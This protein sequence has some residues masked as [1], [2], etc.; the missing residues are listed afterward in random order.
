M[1]IVNVVK[2][3][4]IESAPFNWGISLFSFGCNLQ[5][6]FCKGYNYEA[7]TDKRNIIGDVLD[8]LEK[9]V[10]PAHDCVIF[11]GG[12]PTIWK[13][14]LIKALFW[15]KKHN[16]KTKIFSNGFD[17]E[18]IRIINDLKLCDAWSIDYKGLRD[19]VG[20][21]IGV[22]GEKYYDNMVKSI[23]DIIQHN[24]PLE[25]RTTYFKNN[26][27][28]K[29]KIRENIK[30]IEDYMNT[31]KYTAYYKYFEQDDFRDKIKKN[32]S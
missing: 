13:N 17:Y 24:L 19:K 10:T 29:N 22:N 9:E 2:D 32:I 7:V 11:I 25:I 4:F 31:N 28:D 27:K 18:T 26:I 23:K 1:K 30:K 14:D 3:S 15:C 21:Y 8:I 20:N 12:E 6:S 5:C 16:K